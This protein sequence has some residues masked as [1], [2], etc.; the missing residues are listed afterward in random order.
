MLVEPCRSLRA[1]A[2]LPSPA[3][4][5]FSARTS[6]ADVAVPPD[7]AVTSESAL[8]RLQQR[9]A[10]DLLEAFGVVLVL[11]PQ[12][13]AYASL[14]GMP[15][16]YGLYAATLPLIAAACF[17]SS[18]YLQTG[19][20]AMTSLLTFAAIAPLATPGSSEYVLLAP[21]LALVVGAVRVL[22]GLTGAG[23]FAYLLSQPAL[24][25]FSSAA[26]I[27]ISA[28]QVPAVFAVVA[29]AGDTVTTALW[30]L[31]H[32]AQWSP[33]AALACLATIVVMLGGRSVHPLFPGVLVAVLLGI[34]VAWLGI[35]LGPGIQAVRAGWPTPSLDLPWAK[36]PELIVPGIVIA[37]VG[38]AEPAAIARTLATQERTP[39]NADRELLAQGAANIASGVLGAFPVGG[40]FSRTT[41]A[42]LAGA[43]TRWCGAMVGVL[44]CF[45]LPLGP[46]LDLVPSSVLA[47][48]VIASVLGLVKLRALY[49]LLGISRAQAMVAWSTFLLTILLAPRIDVAVL[50]GVLLVVGVHLWRERRIHVDSEWNEA[51]GELLLE[52][53]GV[54]YFGSAPVLDDALIA[55]LAAHP[56][57]TRLVIDVRRVGRIDYTGALA[58]HR[59]ASDAAVAGLEV[60][61]IPGMRPQGALILERVFGADARWIVPADDD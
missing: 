56:H 20:V 30:V 25:G 31:S 1:P 15:P 22:V 18:A 9:M 58:L 34:A 29:P 8:P 48:I 17:A 57:A 24:I 4:S 35:D 38:F 61:I 36:L 3:L 14:A 21:L 6:R 47:G 16:V 2:C 42:R 52:P 23:F 37:F 51:S 39:W 19:P 60:R 12:A 5:R 28:S 59:V 7:P 49:D 55:A 46:W 44:M 33:G 27:L 50:V 11:V 26:A 54:L 45:A 10:S 41:L 40:S 53:V 43:R 13:L 32:P